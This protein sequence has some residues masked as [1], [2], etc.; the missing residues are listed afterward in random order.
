MISFEQNLLARVRGGQW[1][2]VRENSEAPHRLVLNADGKLQAIDLVAQR[3][4]LP[5][6]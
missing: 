1:T 2:I 6:R 5:R 4:S 3:D